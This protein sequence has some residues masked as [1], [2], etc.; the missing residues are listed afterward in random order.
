MKLILAGAGVK[1]GDLSLRAYEEIKKA[2]KVFI[3]TAE[4]NVGRWLASLGFEFTALDYI[5]KKSRNFYT[6]AKNLANV[7]LKAAKTLNVVYLVD[8]DVKDDVSCSVIAGVRKDAVIIPGISKADYYLERVGIFSYTNYTAISAY[9]INTPKRLTLPLVVFDI[10]SSL[11]ASN[12]KLRLADLFGDDIPCYKFFN[13]RFK[14]IPLYESDY[15]NEFDYSSAIVINEIPLTEKSR[16]TVDDLSEILRILRSPDGC[17]WDKAQTPESIRKNLIEEVYEL[18]D[19]V[20]ND[21]DDA[22]L[23]ETGDVLLQAFFYIQFE[24]E[25]GYFNLNDAVSGIC[26]KLINR[27]THI[28]GKDTA[29]DAGQ[30]LDV[31]EKNKQKE[32][33][34]GCGAEYLESVPESFPSVLRAHKVG[35]RSAKYNMDFS[36]P[37]Q[38][39]DKVK[40]EF[41][42]VLEEYK[43]K[44]EKG[45]YEE[46]GDLLFAVV[47]FV[48]L[49]GV[50]GELALNSAT[51][52][53]LKRFRKT[54]EL[55]I[56]DGKNMKELSEEELDKYYHEAKKY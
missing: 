28:F 38:C 10:D 37:E 19:A 40:E 30:A 56:K 48:R 17:P 31:W 50:N 41:Y 39:A 42:E 1:E 36:S 27:H 35:S 47:S 11:T 45:I 43:K 32:K 21:D 3:R 16:F 34:F 20:N 44:N 5:Y 12:V 46:S 9:D 33:G 15:G 51:D 14:K 55:V 23:E 52:K 53:F 22:I 13:D 7:V 49:L 18:I 4:T 29:K 24:E 25:K 54:E 8:G 2:D 6:L 26:N